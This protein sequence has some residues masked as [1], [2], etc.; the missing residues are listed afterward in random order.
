MVSDGIGLP[1]G[2]WVNIPMPPFQFACWESY[3]PKTVARGCPLCFKPPQK[4]QFWAVKNAPSDLSSSTFFLM[5][6][7]R[8]LLS[9]RRKKRFRKQTFIGFTPMT[10]VNTI[11][12]K[13]P[14]FYLEVYV[15]VL[16]NHMLGLVWSGRW[17]SPLT[18]QIPL[19][20]TDPSLVQKWIGNPEVGKTWTKIFR[21]KYQLLSKVV[22][23]LR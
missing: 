15:L 14:A 18:D 3:L 9:D 22:F 11:S 13:L 1:G 7:V 4:I 23:H 17:H 20:L 16:F 10:R 6:I 19:P 5:R 2:W 12:G 8:S 21:Q